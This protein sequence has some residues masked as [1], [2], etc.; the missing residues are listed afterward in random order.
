MRR[1]I[2]R[3]AIVAALGLAAVAYGALEKRVTVRVDGRPVAVVRTFAGT[4]GEAL[5]RSDIRVGERDRVEPSREESLEDG[6]VVQVFRAKPITLLLDGKRRTVWVT[7]LTIADV[8]EEVELRAT[9]ADL[10]H[11]SR[12]SRVEP[13]MTIRVRR[14]V[15]LSVRHDGKTE[16]VV[17]NA[18][19]IGTVVRE[20]GID[21]GRRDLIRPKAARRPSTGMRIRVLRVGLRRSAHV[22][23]VP[24][25]TYLRRTTGME[26]G[27]RTVV[28]SGRPGLRRVRVMTRFVDGDPVSRRVIGVTTLRS[29]Q[30]RI[31]AIGAGYPGCPCK[32]GEQVGGASWYGQADG[33]TAAH[34]WL[35]FGTVVRVEN[36]ANGRTINV[37]I[38]DRGPYI[39][40]RII[41]LS[42]EAFARLA[43]LSTGVIRVRIR[44]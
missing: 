29:P 36:L 20:L 17:T 34:R 31:I 27:T 40:G 23:T 41:D 14:A 3:A 19:R 6:A 12:A 33:L 22:E 44:W 1:R 15:A 35:P 13:G 9:L 25:P 4:V 10:V 26:Y 30:A 11:P 24:Y 32:D 2:I 42:D 21:L 8:L 43:P 16:R 7:G 39:D 28:Q 38:R 5:D 18:R 37:V